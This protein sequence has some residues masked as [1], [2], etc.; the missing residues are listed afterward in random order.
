MGTKGQHTP[1]TARHCMR[2]SNAR[3]HTFTHPHTHTQRSANLQAKDGS[4]VDEELLAG[5][6][7]LGFN[8][9]LSQVWDFVQ[10]FQHNK[11][12]PPNKSARMCVCDVN[13]NGCLGKG[14][15]PQRLSLCLGLSHTVVGC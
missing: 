15:G 2:G 12:V 7:L 11:L 10:S 4:G 14:K 5:W 6:E 1:A 13:V 3:A 9:Q 8:V